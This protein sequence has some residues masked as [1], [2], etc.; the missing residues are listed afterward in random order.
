MLKCMEW[1]SP[2]EFLVEKH[3]I[4][5]C[6]RVQY[7][8]IGSL[9]VIA[10]GLR[11]LGPCYI[12]TRWRL[13]KKF[14]DQ[15]PLSNELLSAAVRLAYKL[16]MAGGNHIAQAFLGSEFCIKWCCRDDHRL[17][18]EYDRQRDGSLLQT[19]KNMIRA[20]KQF[21]EF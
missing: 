17:Q 1:K 2:D 12:K 18:I 15:N 9:D 5:D 14:P 20:A 4:V 13:M 19:F 21:S 16:A 3:A 6:V 11:I 10:P 8:R 7:L